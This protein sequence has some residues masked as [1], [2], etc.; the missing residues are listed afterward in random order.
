MFPYIVPDY[1]FNGFVFVKNDNN[2]WE[3]KSLEQILVDSD[4]GSIW[5][6]YIENYIVSKRKL[7]NDYLIM[8]F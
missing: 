6:G 4:V 8:I 5:S 7:Q 3:N 2:H 1:E